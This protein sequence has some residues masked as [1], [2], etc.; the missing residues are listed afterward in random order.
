MLANKYAGQNPTDYFIS[1]KLDGLRAVYNSETD[2]FWS[3]TNKQFFA[4]KFFT[5]SFPKEY[6]GKPLIIDGELFMGRGNFD[7]TGIFRKKVPVSEEWEEAMYYVFDLPM[8]NAPFE[9][10]YN[11][12][13][14]IL[15]NI[16]YIHVV[17]QTKITSDTQMNDIHK[18]LVED[19]AEGSIL[20]LRGSY[21]ENKRSKTLLKL[22]DFQDAEVNVI[23]HE[24]GEGRNEGLLGALNIIWKDP[25]MGKA[26]FKVGSGFDDYQRINYKSLFPI[27]SVIT[28]KYFERDK[29]SKKPRFPTFWRVYKE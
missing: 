21:Y 28:I 1:E 6:Q 12:M 11:I 26:E 10:R 25:K 4:P 22:K 2:T 27:S 9:E 13:K 17:E 20:R 24:L 8:I 19:G 5:E 23:G 29:S 3:R 14:D 15:S 18:K 7:K 16:P